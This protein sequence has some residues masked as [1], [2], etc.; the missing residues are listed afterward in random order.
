MLG[1]TPPSLRRTSFGT[2]LLGRDLLARVLH[3][4]RVSLLVGL[5]ATLVTF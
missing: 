4:G 3:G 2:D 1:A 5:V